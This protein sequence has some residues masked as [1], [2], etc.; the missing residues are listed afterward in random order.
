MKTFKSISGPSSGFCKGV[1][2]SDF[3]FKWGLNSETLT[4]I[5]KFISY[6]NEIL[7]F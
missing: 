1:L 4:M 3:F 6:I 7:I 2:N 5:T